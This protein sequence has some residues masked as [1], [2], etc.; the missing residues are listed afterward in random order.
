LQE[1]D[2]SGEWIDRGLYLLDRGDF[3]KAIECFEK[4]TLEE[5]SN[6]HAWFQK[7]IASRKLGKYEEAIQSFDKS[8]V[9][10]PS[11]A[12]AWRR[13]EPPK[14]TWAGMPMHWSLRRSPW[15]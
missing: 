1:S 12:D 4:A 14:T 7:G 11:N 8:I 6:A 5:P 9:L 10:D 2:V 3:E 13:E 15:R